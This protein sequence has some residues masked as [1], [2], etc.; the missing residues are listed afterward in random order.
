[1]EKLKKST[2]CTREKLKECG[3]TFFTER[4]DYEIWRQ[5]LEELYYCKSGL[6]LGVYQIS[7]PKATNHRLFYLNPL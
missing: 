3:W 4:G 5:A 6:I 7:Q 1:M 2:F